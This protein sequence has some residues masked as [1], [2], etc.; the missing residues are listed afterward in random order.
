MREL[1]RTLLRRAGLEDLLSD[2]DTAASDDGESVD[3]APVAEAV[4]AARSLPG[5]VLNES[6]EAL[7]LLSGTTTVVTDAPRS[8]RA[9]RRRAA[10]HAVQELLDRQPLLP[11]D[12]RES[13]PM[14]AQIDRRLEYV[15][16]RGNKVSPLLTRSV[17][18]SAFARTLSSAGQR[19]EA[20]ATPSTSGT[21]VFRT[22]SSVWG[23]S[24]PPRTSSVRCCNH[25]RE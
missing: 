13:N 8:A 20:P 9:T 3:A 25:Q 18:S 2:S 10:K 7:E 4:A 12:F 16:G 5:A 1:E 11:P 21:F 24:G 19:R 17:T 14:F 22:P 23:R 6:A 15:R